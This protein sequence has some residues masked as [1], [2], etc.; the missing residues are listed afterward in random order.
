MSSYD[1]I[2]KSIKELWVETKSAEFNT[3]HLCEAPGAFISATNH[4]LRTNHLGIQVWLLFYHFFF[5]IFYVFLFE[6]I[7]YFIEK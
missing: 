3:L 1:L 5:I 6:Q 2:P 4:F 7:K